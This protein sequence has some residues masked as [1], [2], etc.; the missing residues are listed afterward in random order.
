[1]LSAA[2]LEVRQQVTILTDA[3]RGQGVQGHTPPGPTGASGAQE[4]PLRGLPRPRHRQ[5]TTAQVSLGCWPNSKF[6]HALKGRRSPCN[7]LVIFP[8][9]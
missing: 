1:M 4:R 2:L 6:N 7:S 8:W 5:N 3:F 9:R